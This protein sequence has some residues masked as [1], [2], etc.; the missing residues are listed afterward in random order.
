MLLAG[1]AGGS[2]PPPTRHMILLFRHR[3]EDFELRNQGLNH[4]EGRVLVAIAGLAG[5]DRAATGAEQCDGVT[6]QR[7]DPTG[8]ES[9][10]Q[11]R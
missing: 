6:R 7:A 8:A 10:R 5:F 9:D 11:T 2:A 1:V 3:Q 4:I